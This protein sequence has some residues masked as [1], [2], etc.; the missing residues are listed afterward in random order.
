[1]KI[2]RVSKFAVFGL[3]LA[4]YGIGNSQAPKDENN[5]VEVKISAKTKAI[6]VGEALD[7][8]VEIWNVGHKQ[9]FIEKDIYQLC[10]HSP[11]SLHLDL[12]PSLQ[13][14]PGQGCAGDCMDDPKA[15][16]A[17]RLVERWISLPVGHSYGTVVRMDPDAFPQLRTPGRWRLR[18]Q[19]KSNGDL[20]SS[21]C[22]FS[23][24][25]LDQQMIQK[26]PYKAWR[27]EAATNTLWVEVVRSGN[28]PIANQP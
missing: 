23:P 15:S 5:Q 11:L 27:G 21:L 25:L 19:Y 9:V 2:S 8:Q 1:M 22:V 26:L 14:G 13:P 17:N 28:H 20:S 4:P 18:G 7:V 24:T 16:F 6:R 10:S 12:G 3:I